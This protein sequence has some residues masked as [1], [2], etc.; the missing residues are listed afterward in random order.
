MESRAEFSEHMAAEGIEYSGHGLTL[1]EFIQSTY[2]IGVA[3]VLLKVLT[4]LLELDESEV[5]K[6]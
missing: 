4:K 5:E 3:G 2:A 1:D 6:L